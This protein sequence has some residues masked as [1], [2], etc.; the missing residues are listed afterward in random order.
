MSARG[1][2]SADVPGLPVPEPSDLPGFPE[3]LELGD[4]PGV[5]EPPD[6]PDA[7]DVPG[8]S[9]APGAPG[10]PE[11]PEQP[12]LPEAAEGS[13]TA[14]QLL[15]KVAKCKQIS[16]G[17]YRTDQKASASIPVCDAGNAVFWKADMDIDCD[18]R[19][20]TRCNRRTDPSFQEAT[21][22]LQSDGAYLNA[23]KLPFIV[24]P[25]PS[26]IWNYKSS[27]IRGGSVAAVV[28]RGK[29]QYAV[30]GDTGPTG[31]IG[32]A[33]YATAKAL[34]IAPNPATGGTPSGVTYI[35]FKNSK[36]SP[37]ESHGAAV[38]LGER[39]AKNFVKSR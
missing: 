28:Y 32:E 16:K 7:P 17:K 6:V 15:A 37:I 36:A 13:V 31:I 27:G 9:G 25:T 35:V 21:A 5:P 29:V 18:G 38:T 33:S 14:A 2:E 11:T 19:R 23:E 39:L 10:V 1:E 30:V 34:G 26:T 4:V 3:A 8:V 24:V 20:T 12:G 22:F